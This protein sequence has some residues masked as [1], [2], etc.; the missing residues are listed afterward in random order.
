MSSICAARGDSSTDD[1]YAFH[2]AS[3]HERRLLAKFCAALPLLSLLV[4]CSSIAYGLFHKPMVLLIVAAIANTCAWFWICSAAVFGIAGAFFVKGALKSYK[5]PTNVPNAEHTAIST[6]DDLDGI[7]IVDKVGHLIVLPNFKED[8]EMLAETL[9]S[10]SQVTEHA[11]LYVVLAM[12]EREFGS[13][14]KGERLKKRFVNLLHIAV[15]VHP[16]DLQEL[17]LDGS[18]DDEVP[19]KASNLKWAVPNGFVEFQKMGYLKSLSSV[20][21]TV[22]DS[23]CIFHPDYFSTVSREFNCLRE[24]PGG[25]HLWTMWQAPQLPW[26]NYYESIAASRI[27]GYIS[28]AYETGGVCSLTFGGS[29]MVFSGYSMPLQLAMDAGA[30]D[31]DVIA[32]D[33]HAFLKCFFYS[34]HVDAKQ[35]SNGYHSCGPRL[36]VRPV[37]L[38]V[39]STSVSTGSYWRTCVERWHQARR[40]AQGVSE[41]SYAVLAACDAFATLPWKLQSFSL[42]WQVSKIIV[43]LW[44]M[45]LL[46]MCQAIALGA[47]TMMWLYH[48]THIPDCFSGNSIFEVSKWSQTEQ[49]EYVVCSLA[50][51]RFLVWPIVIPTIL[52]IVACYLLLS[53]SF[54]QDKTKGQSSIWYSQDGGAAKAQ[55]GKLATVAL[56]AC[57]LTFLFSAVMIPY[58][59]LAE[60]VAY[61]DVAVHGNR[62]KYITA[63]KPPPSP[64][65]LTYGTMCDDVPDDASSPETLTPPCGASSSSSRDRSPSVTP[66]GGAS[67]SS[68]VRSPSP[69]PSEQL[70][71]DSDVS[72]EIV[73]KVEDEIVSESSETEAAP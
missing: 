64:T 15:T 66:P 28:A 10:L 35:A 29:H 17:H 42:Y 47:V 58:G 57:D 70:F 40:H 46:P 56:I 60:V 8:E 52:V 1:L 34:A 3:I 20:I 25:D 31:G 32:E 13:Q 19:G 12:E 38:P 51:A 67:S 27:W 48:G 59:L 68:S 4:F 72:E 54:L 73:F 62:V 26:R 11:S 7:D 41:L 39:K 2:K 44:C 6:M 5:P 63:A 37:Y 23:D 21:L 45:H 49:G 61:I 24:N 53:A 71:S 50:G 36:T 65:M 33:H 9:H 55:R 69:G 30:W 14:Q 22:A 16:S 43:R 18:E